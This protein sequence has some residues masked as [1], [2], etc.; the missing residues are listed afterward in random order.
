MS[1]LLKSLLFTSITPNTLDKRTDRKKITF[2]TPHI[3]L[4][5]PLLNISLLLSGMSSGNEADHLIIVAM[6]K[7]CLD[8]PIA[9]CLPPLLNYFRFINSCLNP[10][11]QVLTAIHTCSC[12]KGKGRILST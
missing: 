9:F 12:V 6:L 7:T 10:V 2:L 5:Y 8:G 11:K 4:L 3:S 1:C